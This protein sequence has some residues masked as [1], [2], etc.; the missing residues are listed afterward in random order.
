MNYKVIE[1]LG[2]TGPAM[3]KEY[4]AN[5]I[6]WNKEDKTLEKDGVVKWW[7][8]KFNSKRGAEN[9]RNKY[10]TS[11]IL[12]NK[13]LP[14]PKIY[15]WQNNESRNE[16][17]RNITLLF[18]FPIVAKPVAGSQGQNVYTHIASIDQLNEVLDKLKLAETNIIIEEQVRGR[19]YRVLVFNGKIIEIVE[20][21]L[22]IITGDGTSTVGLLIDKYN[23][24]RA[25]GWHPIRSINK[26]LIKE[27]GF[28]FDSIVPKNKSVH[29]TNTVNFHNGADL[30][31][32][33]LNKVHPVN[34]DMFK[35]VNNALG[36]N[37][38][39]IDYMTSSLEVP[40]YIEGHIIEVNN[41][42]GSDIHYAIGDDWVSKFVKQIF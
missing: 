23:N 34:I 42:P 38:S 22:P 25:K 24:D 8:N 18:D 3:L 33:P 1:G 11:T 21:K 26:Q 15:L 12:K 16:N 2:F 30:E 35:T 17:I 27:S 10:K 40:Y 7:G 31:R 9:C 36:V 6:K 5:N 20:R 41:V 28:S 29:V 19:N 14:V 4:K 37:L 13:N 39:G 32:I